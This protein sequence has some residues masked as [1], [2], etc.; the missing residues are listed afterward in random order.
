LLQE[1]AKHALRI[2]PCKLLAH[3]AW[4]Q[5]TKKEY[6]GVELEKVVAYLKSEGK[7]LK[8]NRAIT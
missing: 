2:Q 7:G 3:A 8:V 6:S 5:V 1:I 4:E